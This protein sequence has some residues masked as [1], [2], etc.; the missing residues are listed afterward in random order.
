MHALSANR[1]RELSMQQNACTLFWGFLG[2]Y[3]TSCLRAHSLRQIGKTD[4]ACKRRRVLSSRTLFWNVQHKTCACALSSR[5][6]FWNARHE[7]Y[8]C[9]L[10]SSTFLGVCDTRHMRAHSLP[11]F[12]S[13]WRI[14]PSRVRRLPRP[15]FACDD[16][17]CHHYASPGT[18]T[19]ETI[20]DSLFF[21]Q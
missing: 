16:P 17:F 15:A 14:M 13:G 12:R 7:A 1:Q 19:H 3:D 5:P 4:W 8:A 18:Q 6:F 21:S 10:S 9:A 11:H 20:N 2:M